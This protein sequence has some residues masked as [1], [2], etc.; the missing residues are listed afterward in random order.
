ML[1]KRKKK[2]KGL[3]CPPA[4]AAG[5][6]CSYP[7]LAAALTGI[8]PPLTERVTFLISVGHVILLKAF[9][10]LGLCY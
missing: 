9:M 2:K 8:E 1:R 7:R 5:K 6:R 3:Y 10:L 4:P